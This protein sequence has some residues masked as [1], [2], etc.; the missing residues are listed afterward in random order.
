MLEFLIGNPGRTSQRHVWH[1]NLVRNLDQNKNI[2]RVFCRNANELRVFE[3]DLETFPTRL[4]GENQNSN[5]T[6]VCYI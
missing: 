3:N 1:V 5:V 4:H 6:R 2:K